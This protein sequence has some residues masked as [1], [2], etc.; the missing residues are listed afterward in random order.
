M[1]LYTY[2]TGRVGKEIFDLYA[3]SVKHYHHLFD[4]TFRLQH[5][6]I[7]STFEDLIHMQFVFFIA[8]KSVFFFILTELII[9][10]SPKKKN[11]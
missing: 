3:H 5:C 7:K 8:K 10:D 9:H 4:L 6:Q 1:T 11:A 2:L